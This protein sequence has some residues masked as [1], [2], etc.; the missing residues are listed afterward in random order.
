MRAPP[1]CG[2]PRLYL[3]GLSRTKS[4]SRR[5]AF[6]VSPDES[7]RRRAYRNVAGGPCRKHATVA[8]TPKEGWA[9]VPAVH[10]PALT[11]E[12]EAGGEKKLRPRR[13]APP[14]IVAENALGWPF[15]P[16]YFFRNPERQRAR[17]QHSC[18][19][20]A[21]VARENT[22][23]GRPQNRFQQNPKGLSVRAKRIL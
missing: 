4:Q 6:M 9:S 5:R 15:F 1:P 2:R 18:A 14:Q 11:G 23:A 10:H 7:P 17:V 13:E 16:A 22:P 21:F 3:L 19:P 20:F 8:S 12:N